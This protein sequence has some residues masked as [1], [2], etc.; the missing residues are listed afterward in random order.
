MTITL[1]FNKPLSRGIA[2]APVLLYKPC[3]FAFKVGFLCF[4]SFI[5]FN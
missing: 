4:S 1:L 2:S 5:W 3:Y